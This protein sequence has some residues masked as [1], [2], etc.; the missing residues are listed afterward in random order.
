[1]KIDGPAYDR[2]RQHFWTRIEQSLGA[3]FT[4]ARELTPPEQLAT[5]PWGRA[6]RAA[7]VEAYERSCPRR[8]PRQIQ[9]YAL[10]LR[11]LFASAKPSKLAK[12]TK[13]KKSAA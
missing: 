4:V 3:L 8:T 9:A 6:V 12:T 13:A 2:A 1:L 10:G 7:A 11:H 5:S